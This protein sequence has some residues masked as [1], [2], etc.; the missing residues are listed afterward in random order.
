MPNA[1]DD[2]VKVDKRRPPKKGGITLRSSASQIFAQSDKHGVSVGGAV[3][4]PGPGA[5]YGAAYL[6][7]ISDKLECVD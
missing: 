1:S 3:A 6:A 5:I 7:Q 2:F 4:C